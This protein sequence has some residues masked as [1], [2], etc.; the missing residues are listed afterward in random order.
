MPRGLSVTSLV[1]HG[2]AAEIQLFLENIQDQEVFLRLCEDLLDHSSTASDT[3]SSANAVLERLRRWQALLSV[4]RGAELPEHEV[5]GL[6]GELYVLIELILPKWGVEV[7]LRSWTAPD[8]SPQDFLLP[9][10][11]IEVKT[12]LQEA[13]A[14]VSISSLEQLHVAER[15]LHLLVVRV[16][17]DADEERSRS[18][19]DL[20][21]SLIAL[22]EVFDVALGDFAREQLR[23]RGFAHSP[24]YDT[25]R[26]IVPG[27]DGFLV[28]GDFPRLTP[29]NVPL[30][31][32]KAT[33]L[34]DLA[35]IRDHSVDVASIVDS[36]TAIR[37]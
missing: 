32:T 11:L 21:A 4:S 14:C 22:A 18:L 6:F 26:Y 19:N 33:Y 9:T 13:E 2:A 3:R 30:G 20:A 12:R 23:K 10:T 37:G 1:E 34:L 24:R 5:R 31:V 15:T 27:T 29:G 8:R 16:V 35:A 36:P 25:W 17:S 28:K 7:A